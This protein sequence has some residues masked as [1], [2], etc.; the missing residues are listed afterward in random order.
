MGWQIRLLGRCLPPSP[1]PSP[2]IAGGEGELMCGGQVVRPRG[3]AFRP[4]QRLAFE[5]LPLF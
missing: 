2:P 4:R 3:F 5:N 1:R